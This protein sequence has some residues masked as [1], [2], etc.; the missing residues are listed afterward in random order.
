VEWALKTQKEIVRKVN[1]YKQQ[2]ALAMEEKINFDNNLR[3]DIDLVIFSLVDKL[4]VL[5]W[6]LDLDLP[7]GDILDR[8]SV[9]QH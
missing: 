6:I 3:P 2:L 7:D 8:L 4:E 9:I 5:F 1:T